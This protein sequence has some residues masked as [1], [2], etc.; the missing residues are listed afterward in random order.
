MSILD[1]KKTIVFSP[2]VYNLAETTRCIEI[3]K[4]CRKIFN[5]FF[6]SYGGDFENLIEKENYVVEFDTGAFGVSNIKNEERYY[7]LMDFISDDVEIVGN[8]YENTELL[9]K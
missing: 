8:I 1:N 9:E 4:V 2:A 7:L 6:I 3:A 5:I